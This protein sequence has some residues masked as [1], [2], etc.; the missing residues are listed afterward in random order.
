MRRKPTNQ[1]EKAFQ[2]LAEAASRLLEAQLQAEAQDKTGQ[3]SHGMGVP[4][5]SGFYWA[6]LG[7]EQEWEPVSVEYSYGSRDGSAIIQ[8]YGDPKQYLGSEM[9][10]ANIIMQWGSKLER[11]LD[12]SL[13]E[14]P[15]TR[16]WATKA[17][18]DGDEIG[19]TSFSGVP[20]GPEG[21]A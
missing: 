12:A 17:P 11:P 18:A 3:R 16:N 10:S 19:Y 4:T 5:E 21:R 13:D 20:D 15:M 1:E 14:I 7:R 8:F 2:E 6:L 9:E